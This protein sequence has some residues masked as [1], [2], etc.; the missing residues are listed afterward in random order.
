LGVDLLLA[1]RRAAWVFERVPSSTFVGGV[2][3]LSEED[4][5]VCRNKL[6]QKGAGGRKA[7]PELV[8][9]SVGVLLSEMGEPNDMG[10]GGAVLSKMWGSS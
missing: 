10:D 6:K 1:T 5:N 2:A 7:R 4:G 8:S 9:T 3:E